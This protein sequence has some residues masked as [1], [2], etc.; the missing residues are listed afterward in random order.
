MKR[1]L[2][3]M[4]LGF[5]SIAGK[6]QVE[7][8]PLFTDNMVMQQ[9]TE[10]A[11]LWGK[12]KP[13][14][15]VCV[16]TSWNGATYEAQADSEGRWN[17]SVSTAEAG[18]PYTITIADGTKKKT[19]LQNVM[20]GEVW[21]CS[22]Q[23]NMEMPI[24]GWGHV[25]NWEAEEEEANQYP[26]IRLLTVNRA[27]SARPQETFVSA[28]DGWQVCNAQ[29]VAN[30]SACG[31]FFGRELHK[32]YDVPVGLIYSTWGGTGIQVW[33]SREAFEGQPWQEED[34]AKLEASAEYGIDQWGNAVVHTSLYNA[35]IHPLVPYT[36]KGVIWYQGEA[37]VLRSYQYRELMP[38]MINDW[39]QKWGYE[40]PFYMVQLA[41]FM[42]PSD[43]PQESNWAEVREAQFITRQTM[44]DVGM[45][46]AI[47]VGE[48]ADIHPKNKQ[49]VGHRLA[50]AARATA[51]GE[52][53]AYEGPMYSNYM[54]EGDKIRI[55]FT[56]ATDTGLASSDGEPLNGFA[57]A[58]PDH[59]WH[60]AKATIEGNSVVVSSSD[61]P[62]PLAVRY[63]WAHN[64][65]CNL[66][67]ST[68]LPAS[69]F[70]TDQWR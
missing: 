33:M 15:S 36:L 44:R 12:A 48:A 3:A 51:Y 46:V 31:Y 21:L 57:I 2:L 22:G 24:E 25:R 66:V 23:S 30:F 60:W 19:Q 6:A 20:L 35:M 7:L 52:M 63:A 49:E 27:Q 16:T 13:G 45:A 58:G 55:H 70:R 9:L 68:G 42:Q 61:V 38:M 29:T 56:S 11:P 39:R 18:G 64:P 67:N 41:N 14:S 34:L 47:D 1:F 10:A 50:L 53:I 4:T 37:D 5:T 65:V 62:F 32:Q 59:V 28:G 26:N 43:E 8:S 69:P 17:V 54:I 40:F